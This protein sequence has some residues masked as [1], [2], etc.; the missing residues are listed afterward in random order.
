MSLGSAWRF[1]TVQ[2]VTTWMGDCLQMGKPSWCITNTKV[3][4]AFH[5][6]GL[7]GVKD[8]RVYL[9]VSGVS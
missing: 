7:A 4:S 2:V 6:S 9:H 3:N 8:G 1:H 5:S